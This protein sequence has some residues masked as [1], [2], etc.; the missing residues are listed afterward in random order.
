MVVPRLLDLCSKKN[1]KRSVRDYTRKSRDKR[2][3]KHFYLQENRMFLES[4]HFNLV[5]MPGKN[6]AF[7][8]FFSNCSH[9]EIHLFKLPTGKDETKQQHICSDLKDS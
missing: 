4:F 5:V 9:E 8:G 7:V 6:C 2:F 1:E 3:Y